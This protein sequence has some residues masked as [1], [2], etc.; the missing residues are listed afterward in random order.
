MICKKIA[1]N[2]DSGI[3]S[4]K[5]KALKMEICNCD[6][7]LHY[8]ALAGELAQIIISCEDYRYLSDEALPKAHQIINELE[9]EES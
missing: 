6:Q 4:G 3:K 8:K 9:S 5:E 2:I 7:A 1:D